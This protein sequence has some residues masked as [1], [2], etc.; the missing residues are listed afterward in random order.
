MQANAGLYPSTNPTW[1][2]LPG[3]KVQAGKGLR[4]VE[5]HKLRQHDKVTAQNRVRWQVLVEDLCSTRNEED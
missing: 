4:V 3:T 5:I 2:D 1:L